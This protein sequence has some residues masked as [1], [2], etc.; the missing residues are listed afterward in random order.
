MDQPA[1]ARIADDGPVRTIAMHRP[2][3]LN[4]FDG[5][6]VRD[7]ADALATAAA[8]AEVR[9]VVLTGSGRAFSTGA[10]LKALAEP[11]PAGDNGDEPQ[12]S[13]G[14][15]VLL[16]QLADFPKPLLMAVNG[17]AVGFGMTMLA[18]ADVILMS[19]QARLRCPFTELGA[20][21]EAGS[22]YLF[23]KLLGRQ[24]AA[25]T[26]L[27]SEWITAEEAQAMGL[28]W[29]LCE[30]EALL[31]VTHD[32]AQRLAAHSLEALSRVKRLL[33][34]PERAEL[35]AAFEREREELAVFVRSFGTTR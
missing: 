12:E 14:F 18:F 13:N 35:A 15:D 1:N 6:L 8:D 7:L 32:H 33:N 27:S 34:A 17:Y 26:L 11:R 3:R 19:T 28:A 21:T 16:D 5:G 25:W 30:P 4:A 29:R 9:V 2:E 20:P 24:Q 31:P 10:D 23:P 22:S